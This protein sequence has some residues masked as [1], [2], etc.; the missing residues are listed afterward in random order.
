MTLYALDGKQPVMP[1]S[2]NWWVAPNAQIIGNVTFHENA[3]AWFGVVVRG[4]NDDIVIDENTNIQDNAVLH[5]DLGF[6]LSLGKNCVVG[7]MAMLHGCTIGD[8]TL[9]GMGAIVMNG[10]KIG[11]NCLIGAQ[12]FVKEGMEV[13]DNSMVLGQPGKVVKQ[14]SDE[15]AAFITMNADVYVKNWQRFKSGLVALD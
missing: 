9:I 13:P 2:G 11:K 4:D 10:A 7:H 1:E 15:V 6:P 8:N 3:S 12:A 14:V 5:T